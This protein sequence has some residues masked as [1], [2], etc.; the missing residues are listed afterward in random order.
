[1][2]GSPLQKSFFGNKLIIFIHPNPGQP[3]K[4]IQTFLLG[5]S[6]TAS[7]VLFACKADSKPSAPPHPPPESAPPPSP[8]PEMYLYVVTV[9]KL[10]LREAAPNKNA[11]VVS[12]FPEGDFVEGTGEVSANKEEVTLRDVPYNEPYIK[13][14]STT[15][16]QHQGWAYGAA[17]KP[18]YAGP[19]NTSP[20]LGRLSQFSMFSKP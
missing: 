11:K 2:S 19:R 13:V 17:L 16:E 7:A 6:L 18:I 8:K 1:M 14:T 15:P 12:Q 4:S 10:N 20:E 9:D 5:A 3:M